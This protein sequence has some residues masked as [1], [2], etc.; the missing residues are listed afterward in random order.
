MTPKQVIQKGL[1]KHLTK[2]DGSEVLLTLRP[3]L[4]QQGLTEFEKRLPST[5]PDDVKDLLKFTSGIEI[6]SLGVLD[7]LGRNLFALEEVLPFGLPILGDGCGNFWVIDVRQDTGLWETVFFVCHDPSVVV[8]QAPTLTAFLEQI[9]E[10][11]ELPYRNQL[12]YVKNEAVDQ[13]DAVNPHLITVDEVRK[14]QDSSLSA[15]AQALPDTFK[16]VDLRA[17]KIGSGFNYLASGIE[18]KVKR[19]GAELIFAI[20][21]KKTMGLFRRLL[22]GIHQKD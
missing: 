12:S 21:Y 6:D 2:D 10:S 3:G 14:S 11:F 22:S 1:N 15:F 13:I 16:V 7:L 9:I 18:T 4:T 8:V 20:E 19:F 5:M 17:T